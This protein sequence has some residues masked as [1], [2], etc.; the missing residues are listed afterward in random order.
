ML[1]RGAC[2]ASWVPTRGPVVTFSDAGPRNVRGEWHTVAQVEMETAAQR[3]E[4]IRQL[5]A[6]R[7]ERHA[8][9]GPPVGGGGTVWPTPD[10]AGTGVI[11]LQVGP[12]RGD[13]SY[14]SGFVPTFPTALYL[15]GHR[16]VSFARLF[17]SQPWV[18]ASAMWMMT[19]AL[20]VPLRVYRRHGDDPADRLPLSGGDHPL[21]AALQGKDRMSR[22]QLSMALFGPLLVNGNSVTTVDS[23]ANESITLTPKDWRFTQPLMPFRDSIDGFRFDVDSPEF[24]QEVSVDEVLHI[25][26]WSP[27]GP[28]GVSPLQQLGVT[29]QIEDS[30]QRYQRALF[31]NGARPPSAITTSESFLGL[32]PDDRDDLLKQLREDLNAIYT[33]P[34][35]AGKPAL[36]PPGLDW[37]PVGHSSAEAE[38]VEQR[39]ITREEIAAVYQIPPP[40]L[41]ILDKAT[42]SNIA[43][44]RDMTYT[45]CLGPP[46][47]LIEEAINAQIVRNLLREDDIFVEFDFAAVLRGDP[48]EEISA[49]RDAIG[50]AL[51]TP[52][53]GR[54]VMNRTKSEDP[55]MD[56]FYLPF[57]NL[58]PVGAPPV[59]TAV[60]PPVDVPALP[61]G[62]RSLH[63]RSRERNYE[64]PVPA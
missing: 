52:N 23:G 57:N 44:Q 10:D 13:L 15:V 30:A 43:T 1:R 26:W 38:L 33:G 19:R 48:L 35:N 53:E 14:A 18:A 4:R 61:G 11:P 3:E 60:P 20:R 47:V 34:D 27:T 40:L 63:V 17:M 50:S 2:V 42:Y 51:L 21:V 5:D 45:D 46:L 58:Q 64:V 6:Q 62:R 37:K 8:Q 25:C 9:H 12:T 28:I 41:G 39:K 29:I 54:S 49:L 16:A 59:P 32:K 56:R 22:A 55:G 31:Q 36:L 24:S 7:A